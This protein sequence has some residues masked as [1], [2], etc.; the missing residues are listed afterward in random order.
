MKWDD[1]IKK[2]RAEMPAMLTK[3]L[4]QI[5]LLVTGKAIELCPENLGELRN[6]INYSIV[7]NTVH[8]GSDSIYAPHMEFGTRP[9]MPPIEPL[10]R[11]AERKFQKKGEEAERIAW[12]VA[13]KIK[14]RGIEAGTPEEPFMTQDRT[15][16]PFLRTALFQS[17]NNIN[18]IIIKNFKTGA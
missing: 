11:W 14:A 9:H 13:F 1:W 10:I 5:G 15:Y 12:G 7:D 17:H 2:Y 4:N 6:S 16:R 8:V 18:R 3:S